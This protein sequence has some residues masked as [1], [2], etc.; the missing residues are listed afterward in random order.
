MRLLKNLFAKLFISGT[1]NAKCDEDK[2]KIVYLNQSIIWGT[3]MFIPNLLFE[4]YIGFAPAIFLNLVFVLS[5]VICFFIN[6]SGHYN[7]ARSFAII[8]L[9]L[10]ILAAN[11]IEGNQTGNYLIYT[12]LILL[13]PILVKLKD[14]KKEISLLFFFTLGCFLVSMLICPTKGYWSE[15]LNAADATMMFR[16][17]YIVLFGLTSI[18]AYIIYIITQQREIELIKAKELAEE[19]SKVKLQFISNMSH[20]LRTP[21]NGIIGTTNLLQLDVQNTDEQKEQYELLKYS[22]QHMLHLVNDV[23]DFSKIESGKI[24]LENRR[25][26]LQNFIKNI[27][28][29]FAPQ[30]ERKGLYFKLLHNDD[31]LSYILNSDDLRLGQILNNLLSNALKFTHKGGV[32]LGISTELLSIDK[33]KV[34]FEIIDTGIG[35]KKQNIDKVFESFIQADINTTRKYGGTG[36][37][38]SISK[39]LA[40]VFNTMLSVESEPG[41]GS[42]FSFEPIFSISKQPIEVHKEMETPFKNLKGM[43]VLIAED[44]KINMLIA[45]K[46]LR[47]WDVTLTEA[48]NGREAI[49]ICKQH[50][51][52]LV[53]LDLEMPEVDGYT[54]LQEIRKIYPDI[55][56]IAFTAT[57]FENIEAILL[58]QGF[59]DYILKP[60]A[61]HDLNSKLY[62]QTV[63]LTVA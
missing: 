33:L 17:S 58:A 19:S 28:N 63:L 59:N 61:P 46:F 8:G 13:F 18:L 45:R 23:L 25:F 42:H 11:F 51:F 49:D 7:I 47:N 9:D 39:K 15:G 62:K 54:A 34:R 53:L 48:I 60:F 6:R 10:I 2:L 24:E 31:D 44:N 38:L 14:S 1:F 29:S 43:N 30:F 3:I 57:V 27:Y 40:E 37:G 5:S 36:L 32:T 52:D 4:L 22:S 55:P 12:A 16:A 26:T 21:L 20:E 41:K 56:A 35:I 50:S